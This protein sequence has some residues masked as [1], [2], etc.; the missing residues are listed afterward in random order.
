MPF[1]APKIVGMLTVYS[2]R[3][4]VA[5]QLPNTKVQL[6]RNGAIAQCSPTT[7][8]GAAKSTH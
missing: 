1:V 5:N 3:I 2:K 7:P 4:R 6:L 8:G